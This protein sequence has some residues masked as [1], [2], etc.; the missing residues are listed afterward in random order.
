LTRLISPRV[1]IYARRTLPCLLIAAVLF[2]LAYD[3]GA[4]DLLPRHALAIAVWWAIALLLITGLAPAEPL[5]RRA[6]TG[7]ALLV[8]FTAWTGL[9]MAWAESTE[10]AVLELDRAVLYLGVFVLTCLL[11]R[12]W[13]LATWCDGL[14]IGIVATAALALTSRF[15]PGHFRHTGVE[16]L[17]PGVRGRL[18]Y[19][20]DYWN[21]LGIFVALSVPL[22][23]RAATAGRR[24]FA[25]GVALAPIPGIAAV[26][27]LT[28]SRGAVAA[29]LA[30][31]IVFLALAADRWLAAAAI[32][33]SGLGGLAAVVVLR[34]RDQLVNGF[35]DSAAAVSQGHS[36]AVWVA[37]LCLATGT[38]YA[39]GNRALGRARPPAVAGWAGVAVVVAAAVVAIGVS[40]PGHAWH[41]FKQPPGGYGQDDFTSAHLLS[42]RGNGR[43]Q[44]WASAVSEFKSKPLVGRGA[45]SWE[46][47]WLQDRPISYFTRYAHSL[48]LQ[49]LGELGAVGLVLLLGAFAL[50]VVGGVGGSKS[51]DATGLGAAAAGA[52]AA[53]LVG[54]GVDWMWQMPVVSV[55]GFALLG[56]LARLDS[57]VGALVPEGRLRLVAAGLCAAAALVAIG[58]EA[59]PML[60]EL[61]IRD[62]QAAVARGDATAAQSDAADAHK[63]EPWAA[64]PYLQLALL[65]EQ[66]GQLA[67]ANRAIE[68]ATVRDPSNWQ[69]WLVASRL[70]VKG[71]AVGAAVRSIR[72]A[73]AL[74]PLS[75]LLRQVGSH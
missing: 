63:L 54:A 23:L 52:F 71:S 48:Y 47:W 62:S 45:G 31:T 35:L 20:L 34:G 38:I 18:T 6:S 14:A 13:S 67:A 29:G 40:H 56:L 66:A 49:V 41:D 50:I 43:W 58:V 69:L 73:R 30:G 51:G 12:R 17:L 7:G 28:S 37:V 33:V 24:A 68:A 1:L 9:S 44:F 39:L 72:H 32:L 75:P 5:G 15:F 16:A 42:G 11:A 64:T 61:K 55:V 25:R 60:G 74:D 53:F 8:L 3:G 22:L 2:G 10:R 70:Q 57:R 19:P 59:A 26:I 65:Y 21:G 46:A 27:Y 36:A 4:Y